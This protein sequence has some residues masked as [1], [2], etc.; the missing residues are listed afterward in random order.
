LTKFVNTLDEEERRYLREGF[1]ND[2]EL[3][4]YDLLLKEAI[5]PAEIKKVKALAKVLLERI[6][7]TIRTLD[8][9]R[10]KPAT[11]AAVD[12]VIRDTLWQE[13]PESYDET[14]I[15]VYRQ[16]IYEFAFSHYPAA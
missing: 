3:A 7:A 1:D 11:Q 2:E 10:E 6:K 12:V 16:Q 13:L 4:I 14:L 9:W 5:T 15:N 8:N